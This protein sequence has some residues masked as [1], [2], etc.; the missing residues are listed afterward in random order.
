MDVALN[1]KTCRAFQFWGPLFRQT[2]LWFEF[3]FFSKTHSHD[4]FGEPV[5][6][7]FTQGIHC[8]HFTSSIIELKHYFFPVSSP[9]KARL[10]SGLSVLNS[11]EITFSECLEN[12]SWYRP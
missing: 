10:E 6:Q 2:V 11:L 7:H 8:S 3:H 4:G 1:F 9:V 12:G 5:C